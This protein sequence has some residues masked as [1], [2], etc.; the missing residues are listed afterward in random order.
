MTQSFISGMHHSWH[1]FHLAFTQC[2]Q[3]GKDTIT[4]RGFKSACGRDGTY[5][6]HWVINF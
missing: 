2:G 6:P 5:I 3:T 4:A 1:L